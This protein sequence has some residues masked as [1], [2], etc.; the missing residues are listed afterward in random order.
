MEEFWEKTL[1]KIW[2]IFG[3]MELV[4]FREC[5]MKLQCNYNG[6]MCHSLWVCIAWIISAIWECK[7]SLTC[8][9]LQGQKTSCNFCTCTLLKA[10]KYIQNILK[11]SPNYGFGR[12]QDLVQC[13]DTL[14]LHVITSTKT[15]LWEYHPFFMKMVVEG[16]Q[17][18]NTI[19]PMENFYVKI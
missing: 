14:N 5:K 17:G 2:F 19:D 16:N 13:E 18:E 10:Q 4:Y 3:Q 9:Q 11:I 12:K 7:H 15:I 8:Q 6:T 1:L